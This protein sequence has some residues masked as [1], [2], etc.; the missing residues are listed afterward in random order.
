MGQCESVFFFKFRVF[1]LGISRSLNVFI[2]ALNEF[3]QALG[4][5]SHIATYNIQKATT[6]LQNGPWQPF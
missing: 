4:E 6:E 3:G 2:G 5:G 1:W